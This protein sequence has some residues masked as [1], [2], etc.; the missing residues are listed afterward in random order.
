MYLHSHALIHALNI[1]KLGRDLLIIYQRK[2]LHLIT[3]KYCNLRS[4]I[5]TKDAKYDIVCYKILIPHNFVVHSSVSKRFT[6]NLEPLPFSCRNRN[7][8]EELSIPWLFLALLR[9]QQPRY[10]I[11][12]ISESFSFTK[13]N[14]S[15]RYLA[16]SQ[17]RETPENSKHDDVIKWKHFLRYLPFVQGIRRLPVNSPHKGQRRGALMFSLICV[18]TNG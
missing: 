13:N 11:R 2:T 14:F 18:W 7:I 1:Y 8:H 9:H 12:M 3:L 16:P 6:K 15:C 17:C 10:W 4:T 5:S